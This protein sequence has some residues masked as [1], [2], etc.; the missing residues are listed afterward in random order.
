MVVVHVIR[1]MPFGRQ[2]LNIVVQLRAIKN[3]I[4]LDASYKEHDNRKMMIVIKAL[5]YVK[6][7]NVNI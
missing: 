6:C 4:H 5:E 7:S 2:N 3:M 1:S